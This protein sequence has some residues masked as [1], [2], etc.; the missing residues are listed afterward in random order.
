MNAQPRLSV[1]R[2]QVTLSRLRRV[3][4]RSLFVLD[5]ANPLYLSLRT[6]P[7]FQKRFPGTP[8][9]PPI[10]AAH[11]EDATDDSESRERITVFEAISLKIAEASLSQIPSRALRPQSLREDHASSLGN[12]EHRHSRHGHGDG[13]RSIPYAGWKDGRPALDSMWP[14]P[15]ELLSPPSD[16]LGY[17]DG[18]A[19]RRRAG[20]PMP[21]I[22]AAG[23]PGC[24][25]CRRF[26]SSAGDGL[27]GRVERDSCGIVPGRQVCL[28]RP[29]HHG[30]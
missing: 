26:R 19:R 18:G 13:P 23:R 2:F 24:R 12:R 27:A 3:T 5:A 15:S 25:F 20:C 17:S 9:L 28:H 16:G 7:S 6:R 1:S 14:S 21:C 8:G 10:V 22:K 29:R 11:Q 4:A 30:R